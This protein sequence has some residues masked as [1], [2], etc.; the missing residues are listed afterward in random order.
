MEGANDLPVVS[1]YQ[2]IVRTCQLQKMVS[3][4]APCPGQRA[5]M[6]SGRGAFPRSPFDCPKWELVCFSISDTEG[7]K[8]NGKKKKVHLVSLCPYGPWDP[9]TEWSYV[10]RRQGKVMVRSR[11]LEAELG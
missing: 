1:D 3:L 2:Q 7:S 8:R 5:G 11:A 4:T 10:H 9:G 6:E